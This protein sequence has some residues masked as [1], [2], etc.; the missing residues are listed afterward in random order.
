[1]S[2]EID[3]R[4]LIKIAA[5]SVAAAT[6][7][8]AQP[9]GQGQFFTAGELAL[10][11]ELSDILIPTDE[12]SPGAK[13]AKVAAFIDSYFAQAYAPDQ[14]EERND[15]RDGLKLFMGKSHEEHIAMFTRAAEHEHAARTR[16]HSSAAA[17]PDL[18]P[19]EKFYRHLKALTIRGY[20]TT[21]IGIHQDL[22]YKG[23]VFQTG[24][25]AGFLPKPV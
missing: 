13:A 14:I 5:V 22:D 21:S 18:T 2:N 24:E 23:N 25:Y 20:Y 17:A 3:R 12:K 11:D 19:E 16:R 7:A 8:A 6:A 4:E 1:M 10:T 15:F 9:G